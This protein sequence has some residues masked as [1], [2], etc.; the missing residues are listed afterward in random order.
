MNPNN[1]KNAPFFRRGCILLMLL[2]ILVLAGFG[3]AANF[4]HFKGSWNTTDQ[5]ESHQVLTGHTY[6]VGG[7]Y[8]PHAIIAIDN[9]YVL[10]SPHWR[11]VDVT[12]E[13]LKRFVENIQAQWEADYKTSPK[14]ARIISP[15]GQLVGQWYAIY[16][17]SRI[18][19]LAD[20]RVYIGDPPD[21][22]PLNERADDRADRIRLRD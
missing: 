19:W 21:H 2:A 7:G 20:N 11:Q 14:G 9:R 17:Y 4:A 12:S 3:C 10:E 13:S 18:R 1:Q 6:Y 15:D 16:D 22:M 8:H 5:F